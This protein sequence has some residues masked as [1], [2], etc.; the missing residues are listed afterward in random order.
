MN[1]TPPDATRVRR[2][3]RKLQATG[4]TWKRKSKEQQMKMKGIKTLV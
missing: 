1:L 4:T 3:A 2:I